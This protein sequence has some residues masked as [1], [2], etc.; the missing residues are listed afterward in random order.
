M[1]GECRNLTSA[2]LTAAMRRAISFVWKRPSTSSNAAMAGTSWTPA[3]GGKCWE[4]AI[5]ARVL[6]HETASASPGC[7]ASRATSSSAGATIAV[8]AAASRRRHDDDAPEPERLA[9]RL[10]Q[11]LG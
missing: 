11:A 2:P 9:Q 1:A 3:S 6:P 10:G 5:S 7:R 4:E 8:Q